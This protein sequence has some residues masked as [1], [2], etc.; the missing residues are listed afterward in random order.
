[1]ASTWLVGLLYPGFS[2]SKGENSPHSNKI[3][4]L[5][6]LKA[7]WALSVFH[8]YY[9]LV[10]VFV[11]STG[12]EHVTAYLKALATFTQNSLN[13]SQQRLSLQNTGMAVMR[14]AVL[15]NWV[16]LT[17]ITAPYRDTCA[18]NQTECP[19]FMHLLLNHM[20]AQ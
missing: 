13:N 7:R 12:S 8:W 17:I 5:P 11:P 3:A 4:S 19:V 10:T 14:K 2:L 6:F 18:V 15:Q 16:V 9:H 1:M 20:R